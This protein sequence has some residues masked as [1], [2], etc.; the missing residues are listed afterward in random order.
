KLERVKD[1]MAANGFENK[2]RHDYRNA[3]LGLIVED[4]HDENVLTCNGLL[5]FIDTVFFI[6]P[7][8]FWDEK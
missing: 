6:K 2:R 7:D 5:Y 1:F 4:L 3:N 8:T